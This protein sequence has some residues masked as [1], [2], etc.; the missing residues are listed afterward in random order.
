MVGEKLAV[1][2]CYVLTADV[3]IDSFV[4]KPSISRKLLIIIINNNREIF[5]LLVVLG[6]ANLRILTKSRMQ[7]DLVNFPSS[8]EWWQY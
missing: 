6:F 3:T 8:Y 7:W 5:C 2:T 4:F 1:N